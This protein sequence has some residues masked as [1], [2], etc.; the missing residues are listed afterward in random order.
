M[1]TQVQ[2]NVSAQKDIAQLQKLDYSALIE[3]QQQGAL[4]GGEVSDIMNAKLANFARQA[5]EAREE[6]EAAKARAA[7]AEEKA[8]NGGGKPKAVKEVISTK[9]GWVTVR[10]TGRG[11]PTSGSVATWEA[12]LAYLASNKDKMQAIVASVRKVGDDAKAHA[13]LPCYS[14]AKAARD[15]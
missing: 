1:A 3:L 4:T 10:Y 13:K 2:K 15:E 14:A 8:A 9:P 6:A 11:F 7:A 12:L 5:E